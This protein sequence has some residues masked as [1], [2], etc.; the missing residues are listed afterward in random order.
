M[1]RSSRSLYRY[2]Q[3]EASLGY[4]KTL[5]PKQAKDNKTKPNNSSKPG[6][7]RIQV[8]GRALA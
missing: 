4:I 2:N 8:F 1:V 6:G 7:L 3:L 5:S